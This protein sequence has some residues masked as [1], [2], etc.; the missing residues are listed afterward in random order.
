MKNCRNEVKEREIKCTEA[1]RTP[2]ENLQ[3]Y[4][5]NVRITRSWS[6]TLP[7]RCGWNMILVG[8]GPSTLSCPLAV[9][10]PP[11]LPLAGT[12]SIWPCTSRS[13][14]HPV[15]RV[16][17]TS[18]SEGTSVSA[19]LWREREGERKEGEREVEWVSEGGR[20]GGRKWERYS[21][22]YSN[23]KCYT[24]QVKRTQS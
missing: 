1:Q 12:R 4:L 18:R 14:L 21:K 9:P 15:H 10:L 22:H 23:I 24:Y 6:S 17:V 11:S 5:C 3:S 7:P 19:V 13:V 8:G 16:V 20:E 2:V